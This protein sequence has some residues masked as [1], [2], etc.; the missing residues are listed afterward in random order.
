MRSPLARAGRGG[1]CL[2]AYQRGQAL[3]FVGI[4]TVIVLLG[5]VLLF[6]VSQLTTQ[7]MK[8]QNTADAAA[9][10]GA[11]CEARDY[12]FTAYANRAMIANQVAV[13]QI[14]GL[15]SWARNLDSVYKSGPFTWVPETF[16]NLS[17]LGSMWTS[18]FNVIKGVAGGLKSGID[19]VAGPLVKVLD[20]LID[21]LY[22]GS[23]A[24]HIAMVLTV[25]E[26]I[27]EV[28]KL[29]D[30]DK[31]R[32]S[33]S[34]TQIGFAAKH[35]YD[36]YKFTSDYDPTAVSG[37]NADS[38]GSADRQANVIWNSVDGFY[39]FRSYPWPLPILIDP[40]KAIPG[41]YG[42]M[43]M[44]MYH[45]GG[46]EL[47]HASSGQKMK[48]WTALDATGLFTIFMAWIFV[49][50][51]IPIPIPIPTPQGYG[52]AIAGNTSNDLNP[53]SGTFNH[54]F[55]DAYG[56]TFVN[57]LTMAPGWIKVGEGPGATLDSNGGLKKYWDVSKRGQA[58]TDPA[59]DQ[60]LTAPELLIEVEKPMGNITTSTSNGLK[61]GGDDSGKLWLADKVPS[62][63][64]VIKAL[65][66]AQAY[67]SRP[68]NLFPRPTAGETEYGSLYSPY[69][70]VR[71]LPNSILEQGASILLSGWP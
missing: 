44:I 18:V 10:S 14:V 67:F 19:A 11:L 40:T 47:K 49:P 35:A 34:A 1:R 55:V 66:K 27:T 29:N 24:Y 6:N 17:A 51:P 16:A 21:A 46:T 57:P 28:I 42:T 7:K 26:T 54:S 65:S 32:L 33:L 60:N 20:L 13:A 59:S 36:V 43:F 12:N 9:Y 15:T 61:I 41:N 37:S 52:G 64:N 69:W 2:V 25:P 23:S 3:V 8:L 53:S 56:T 38:G 45:S 30:D 48:S 4:T 70:Q 68:K 50:F 63:D 58:S 62:D 71:L 22:Y 31:S 5:V 39:K